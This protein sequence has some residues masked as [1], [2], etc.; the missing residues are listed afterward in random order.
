MRA[1]RAGEYEFRTGRALIA[2]AGAVALWLAAAGALGVAGCDRRP[3]VYPA[4]STIHPVI[5][6]PGPGGAPVFVTVVLVKEHG[7]QVRHAIVAYDESG[8][9]V[10]ADRV[11]FSGRHVPYPRDTERVSLLLPGSERFEVVGTQEDF[12]QF[13]SDAEEGDAVPEG[14]VLRELLLPKVSDIR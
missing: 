4:N 11:V 10:R 7:G 2:Y 14:R 1:S 12:Q 5:L 13:V 3:D 9:D 8:A 6:D